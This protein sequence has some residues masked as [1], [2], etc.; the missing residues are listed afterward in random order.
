VK[1]N[2]ELLQYAEPAALKLNT[3]NLIEIPAQRRGT[4]GEK[5]L[6]KPGIVLFHLFQFQVARPT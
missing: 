5:R 4:R 2:G 3:E 1:L 6:P